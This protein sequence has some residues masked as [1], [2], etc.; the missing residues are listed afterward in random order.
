MIDPPLN[1]RRF[2]ATLASTA[3]G[4][5]FFPQTLRA[6]DGAPGSGLRNDGAPDGFVGPMVGHVSDTEAVLWARPPAPGRWELEV[7]EAESDRRVERAV[8]VSAPQNDLCVNWRI[9]GLK[10][11]TDYRYMVS[12]GRDVTIAADDLRFRTAPDPAE[13]SRSTWAFGSCADLDPSTLWT[14]IAERDAEALV[15]LGDTPYIDSTNLNTARDRH[16]AFLSVPELA[17][18]VRHT[19]TWG[20]WDDHDFGQNDSDGRLPGKENTRQA[21]VEYRA[22]REYGGDAGGIYTKFRRGPAEVFLLDTRWF[23]QT[24]PSPVDSSQPTLLGAEQWAWLKDGLKKS[25]APFKFIACGMIWDDKENRESDDWGTYTHE[26]TALFDF[27]GEETIS[28]VVLIGGDIHC[29]RLLKYETTE[30]VGYPIYQMIVSPIHGRTIPSLN[31]PH[32]N[33]VRGEAV[34]HVWLHVT[35]D[36]TA[37]PPALQAEWVQRDGREMWSLKCNADDLTSA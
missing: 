11:A 20:A 6:K 25:T 33:L 10:P 28:G 13:P 32:P 19:P 17:A 5:A 21:L 8:A 3:V 37:S 12:A 7:F 29:S 26:R 16:R 4:A 24:G 15:L 34:P 22:N 9:D 35:V 1:R 27:L 31:V 36:S 18:L 2:Q 14:Q 23:S 30:Q